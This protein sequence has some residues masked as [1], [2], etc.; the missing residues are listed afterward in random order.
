MPGGVGAD[1]R[2]RAAPGSTASD[3]RNVV[4]DATETVDRP[5]GPIAVLVAAEM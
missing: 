3:A 4:A 5:I 2:D 1:R